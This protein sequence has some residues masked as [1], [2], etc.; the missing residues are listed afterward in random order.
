LP[1]PASL[2]KTIDQ[3]ALSAIKVDN[4]AELSVEMLPGEEVA[5]GSKVS[6]RIRTKRSG[7]LILVDVDVNGRLTQIYPN[8]RALMSAE[9]QN[10][11]FIKPEKPFIV[12]SPNDPNAGLE[13]IA[14]PPSG[15]GMVVA[16]LSDRPVQLVD[17]P[18]LPE[19]VTGQPTAL[20]YL[21][22]IVSGL[23][24]PDTD[25]GRLQSARWSFNAKFYSIR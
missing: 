9:Q 4:S 11:N 8:T 12:P 18:D 1:N 19:D 22:K 5:V 24:I 15:R 7:Y 17:L 10:T 21:T 13:Y 2:L 3:N 23:L 20:A 16:M 14:A 6:F 25:T